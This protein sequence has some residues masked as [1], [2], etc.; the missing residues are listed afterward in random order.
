MVIGHAFLR[1]DMS[2]GYK[3]RKNDRVQALVRQ[4]KSTEFDHMASI[5]AEL[6][7]QP[8]QRYEKRNSYRIPKN[9][10]QNLS[11]LLYT[12]DAADE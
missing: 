6:P 8:P 7:E 3:R 12:S 11:C 9:P 4:F 2:I 5:D 10:R 1:Q